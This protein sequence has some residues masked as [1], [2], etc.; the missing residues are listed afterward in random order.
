M[1]SMVLSEKQTKF[2]IQFINNEPLLWR[3]PDVSSGRTIEQEEKW[4]NLATQ[5]KLS[6]LRV[7]SEWMALKRSYYN[8]RS[9]ESLKRYVT[10]GRYASKY[11]VFHDRL[12]FL[13]ENLKEFKLRPSVCFGKQNQLNRAAE[14]LSTVTEDSTS[15]DH[16]G[17]SSGPSSA[18]QQTIKLGK[19]SADPI[20]TVRPKDSQKS[21]ANT[22][23]GRLESTQNSSR[24]S[25]RSLDT[26]SNATTSVGSQ[27]VAQSGTPRRNRLE[28]RRH[29][30]KIFEKLDNVLDFTQ[31]TQEALLRDV[32]DL[33]E[34]DGESPRDSSVKQ[35]F[36]EYIRVFIKSVP[37]DKFFEFQDKIMSVCRETMQEEQ[38]DQ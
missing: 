28:N 18:P 26:T 22:S 6:V 8:R 4:Q 35:A 20:V 9:K 13:D 2:L 15:P 5:L 19:S 3:K 30:R 7:K 31:R 16:R 12:S 36:L 25:L 21:L 11:F 14:G 32:R 10:R 33:E 23:L 29:I 24:A 27:R 38:T 37:D 17:A 34:N 1:N